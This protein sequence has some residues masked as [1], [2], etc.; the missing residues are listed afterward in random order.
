MLLTETANLVLKYFL[1]GSA[2]ISFRDTSLYYV[3][4]CLS[5][6]FKISTVIYADDTYLVYLIKI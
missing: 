1:R 2:G 3:P 6:L 4:K 5:M